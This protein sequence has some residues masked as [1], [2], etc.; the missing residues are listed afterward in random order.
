MA[1]PLYLAMTRSEI[2]EN[3]RIPPAFGWFSK[4][5]G[6]VGELPAWYPEGGMLILTDELPVRADDIPGAVKS[7]T[8]MAQAH[9]FDSLLLDFQRS[10]DPD[11]QA[12]VKEMAEAVSCPV[13]VSECYAHETDCAVLLPP[14][15]PDVPVEEYLRPWQGREVWLE[16]A[17]DGMVIT[18]TAEGSEA[19]TLLRGVPGKGEHGDESLCCHYRVETGEHAV[20]TLRRTEDDLRLLLKQAEKLG[21]TRAVGLYQ[22]LGHLTIAE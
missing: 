18:V 12:F 9:R 14:V 1:L 3:G 7:L 2:L 13:C 6:I 20:F 19:K 16:A 22:E 10:G 4:A 11:A 5:D 21:V 17:L 8:R 15:P